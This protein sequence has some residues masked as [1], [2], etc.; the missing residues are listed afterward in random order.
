MTFKP[1]IEC[2]GC[3]DELE[4]SSIGFKALAK[5]ALKNAGWVTDPQQLD[6]HYCPD[7]WEDMDEE[8]ES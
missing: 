1:L 4:L 5:S 8:D 6:A 3:G 2:D 7:C